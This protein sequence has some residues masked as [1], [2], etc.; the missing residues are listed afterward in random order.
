MVF[1]GDE[2]FRVTEKER[3]KV[4]REKQEVKTG[5]RGMSCVSRK[6]GSLVNIG[7]RFVGSAQRRKK[8]VGRGAFRERWKQSLKADGDDWPTVGG[9]Q[10]G[11]GGET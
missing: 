4:M 3:D 6:R 8:G 11:E 2:R 5:R 1:G 9:T 7:K 10:G